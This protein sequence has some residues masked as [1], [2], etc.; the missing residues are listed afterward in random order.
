[1]NKKEAIEF[2][3]NREF[4]GSCLDLNRIKKL[5]SKLN[6][7]QNNLKYIHVAGSNGKGSCC[8]YLTSV[9]KESG[10]KVGTYTS[11][12]LEKYEERFS[13]N[14]ENISEKSF[15]K[16]VDVLS[17]VCKTLD[18]KPRVFELL[19]AIAF[20]YFNDEKCDVVVLEVGLGGR[21]DGTNVIKESLVS[22]IM[23]LGLEHT[24]ILGDTIDKIA[25]EKAGIIKENGDV[26][27]YDLKEGV[28]TIKN[29]AREKNARLIVST[30]DELNI[31]SEGIDKQLFD[32][33]DYKD[34][35]ISLLGKHQ[36]YNACVVIETIEVLRKKGF[37]ISN[38]NLRNGLYK[39]TWDARLSILNR[40]PLFILDGAHNGQC[41][42]ALADSLSSILD[43]KANFIFGVL[44]DK[45][46]KVIV[47]FLR[48]Y[49]NEFICVTPLSNRAL[50]NK[51]LADE[52]NKMG[53]KTCLAS[54]Y[55]E[56]IMM[57]LDKKEATV[58]CG[59]LYLAGA[60]NANFIDAYKS[61]LR[62]S[63]KKQRESLKD[64]KND[65]YKIV[66]LIKN[67]DEYKNARNIMI[68]K[69]YKNE[70][71]LSE[72]EKDDSKVFAYPVCLDNRKMIA[73]ISNNFI[74]NKHGILE[75]DINS[76]EMKDIDLIIC[77]LIAFDDKLNRLGQGGGYYD[78][79]LK[80][81]KC[82]K[83]GVAFDFQK[84]ERVPVTKLDEKLDIIYTP[85]KIFKR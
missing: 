50:D 20:M 48:E 45:D 5:M 59:S 7:P 83:I 52:L 79:Y 26:V 77:P 39:T 8:A 37:T 73:K 9:L 53:F 36:F 44:K 85:S 80:D 71:D 64:I 31:K 16:Y 57:A 4:Q 28:D 63:I 6:N 58:A 21:L 82:I 15:C 17:Q 27:C 19:T 34:L 46:Y 30:F 51:K 70:V 11:P 3:E 49:V 24:A 81:K 1:M 54:D 72:L 42:K 2:I 65:S 40:D 68:Y 12:H 47:E 55:K 33:K 74:K 13:I 66:E 60:I 84:I 61:Y 67:S 69:S 25:Y 22:V 38:E 23:N 78:N 10:Y 29:V 35:R 32:Y 43:N 41:G 62:K 76:I 18:F 56:A 14:N 75:P